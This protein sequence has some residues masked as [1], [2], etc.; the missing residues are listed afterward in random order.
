MDMTA[1]SRQIISWWHGIAALPVDHQDHAYHALR[2]VWGD[3]T[4]A[5]TRGFHRPT[6]ED[7][8]VPALFQH[9]AL[10]PDV[11]WAVLLLREINITIGAIRRVRWAYACEEVLDSR[12]RPTR[13]RDFVIPDIVLAYED[14]AG[15]GVL[16][17]EAKAPGKAAAAIDDLKLATN[18]ALPSMRKLARRNGCL[19]VSA[20]QA[21]KSR[22]ACRENWPVLTWE[23][24]GQLQVQAAEA[25]ALS[26]D[27]RRLIIAWLHQHFARHGVVLA[28]REA[29]P[30]AF[31]G[32]FG[33]EDGYALIDVLPIPDSIRRFLKGSEC[34]EAIWQQQNPV[35]PLPWLA[36]EPDIDRIAIMRWQTT[37][38]RRI[39][40]W[41]FDWTPPRERTWR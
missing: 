4:I 11:N 20:R 8:I 34:V 35:P 29:S 22:H 33:T 36:G 38:D 32:T 18:I 1:S 7:H 24:L 39:G 25:L 21:E 14:D 19:L 31:S 6:T 3:H 15:I 30:T 12:L 10:F 16:V 5:G 27:L 13:G 41:S 9:W 37:E 23:R 26:Q 2:R 40:R 28:G 17:F